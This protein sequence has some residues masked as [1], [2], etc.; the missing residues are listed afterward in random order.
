V[1]AVAAFA[2][3]RLLQAAA[4]LLLATFVFQGALELLPGDPIRALF[5]PRRPDPGLYAALEAQYNFD[6]PFLVRYGKYLGDLLTGD[7]GTSF[8]GGTVR[9][10]VEQGPPIAELVGSALPVSAALLGAA[11]VA[12]GAVGLVA[13]TLSALM[14]RRAAGGLIY[15]AAIGMV[16]V[17]VIVLAYATQALFAVELRWLPVTGSSQGLR[18]Y[19]LPVLT[20]CAASAAHLTLLTRSELLETLRT[21]WVRAAEARSIPPH[22]IVGLHAL[23]A[24][25]VPLVTFLGAN[26]G[27]L[28]TGLVVVEGV[29][30]LPGLGGALFEAIQERDPAVLT[31]LLTLATATVITA[32]LVADVLHAAADPRVR[33]AD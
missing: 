18:S 8:P 5:G 23:R 29:F 14:R 30:G 20:L 33:L 13:G 9:S 24:S 4:T 21:R 1:S 3:R 28:L 11:L 19:V 12:Q 15:L 7:W 10:F 17:P 26:A 6:D 22:R 25:L 31:A 2:A 27:Q 32:N 16:S